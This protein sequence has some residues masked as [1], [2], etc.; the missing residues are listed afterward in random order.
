MKNTGKAYEDLA[1][2]VF[3]RLL[4]AQ[5]GLVANVQRDVDVQGHSTKHQLDVAFEFVAGSVPYRTIVQCKDWSSLVKQ[6]QVLSFNSVL[7]DIPGQPRGIIVSR[8]G[9]QEGARRV[10]EHHGIKL[11]ELRAPLDEDWHGLLREATIH[12]HIREPRFADFRPVL[13]VASIRAQLDALGHGQVHFDL[14]G[15]PDE[16]FMEITTGEHVEVNRILN[17]LVPPGKRPC[18]RSS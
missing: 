12:M 8:S 10:A 5:G 1:E 17:S 14:Q 7:A 3:K 2:Q 11:Y 4:A 13:D 6:E 9:F 16:M 18:T 15:H